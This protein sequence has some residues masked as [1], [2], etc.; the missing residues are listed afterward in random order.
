[1]SPVGAA[2]GG[3]I[4]PRS[5]STLLRRPPLVPLLV[6]LVILAPISPVVLAAPGLAPGAPKSLVAAAGPGDGQITLTWQ[7]PDGLPGATGYRVYRGTASGSEMLL[8]D[9]GN[10]L[11][12][13]DSQLPR[14]ST[15][16]YR[17]SA[18]NPFGEGPQSNEANATTFDLPGAP[19]NLH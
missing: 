7:A 16:Y 4:M 5:S 2:T 12:F 9:I 11:T 19:R 13:T 3:S 8:T 15:Y 17:V 6:A 18:F 10:A 1:M 14:S